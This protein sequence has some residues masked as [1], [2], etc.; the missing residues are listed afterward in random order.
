[1]L[2]RMATRR[3]SSGTSTRPKISKSGT[4][5]RL[6]AADRITL[7]Q[8]A[9]PMI[10]PVHDRVRAHLSDVISSHFGIDRAELPPIMI[11]MP[12]RW[13]LGD[14]AVPVAFELARRLRKAPR[15]IAQDLVAA[16]GALPGISRIEAA[17]NGYLNFF[18]D[19][20]AYVLERLGPAER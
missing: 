17:P 18:I 9:V 3:R 15:A 6:R 16:L 8:L 7:V 2:P 1:M 20:P 11:E 14:L 5:P 13:A 19:R 10:L 12:P 4:R